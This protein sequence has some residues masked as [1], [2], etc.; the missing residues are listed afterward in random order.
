[1]VSVFGVWIRL[2]EERWRHIVREHPE[3]EAVFE[4]VLT[5]VGSPDKVLAGNYGEL[6]A[7]KE[8]GSGKF[9]VVVYKE[10]VDDGFVI[11]AFITSRVRQLEKKVI[12]WPKK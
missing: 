5:A 8:V 4:Q 7:I 1:M 9:L 3:L 10:S 11:T 2:P 12:V 6:L